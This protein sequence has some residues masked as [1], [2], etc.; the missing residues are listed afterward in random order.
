MSGYNDAA[1]YRALSRTA[2]LGG[3][4]HRRAR[5]REGGVNI[6][7]PRSWKTGA[8]VESEQLTSMR[9]TKEA[10]VDS[11]S[12]AR[13]LTSRRREGAVRR[14]ESS[15]TTSM[16]GLAEES[17]RKTLGKLCCDK[18]D[19]NH[20]TAR[21]P[22]YSKPRGSHPDAQKGKPRNIGEGSG[23]NFWTDGD[24][25]RMPGDGSCLFH[26][27]VYGKYGHFPALLP[28][29]C[30]KRIHTTLLAGL[31]EGGARKLRLEI[32]RFIRKNS[33]L[34]IADS[35]LSDWIKWAGH[36]S[37]AAYADKIKTGAWGEVRAK[38]VQTKYHEHLTLTE[39]PRSNIRWWN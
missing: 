23:G 5:L 14:N 2:R 22:H 37:V 11:S 8:E 21:C 15:T 34:Q 19:G 32:A 20:A 18:C 1:R 29:R 31:G 26:S 7:Q 4:R 36:R 3:R 33:S 16:A 38:R 30:V 39:T 24:I 13:H 17:K 12:R 10:L 28:T 9:R 35:P 6:L 25:V 27:L